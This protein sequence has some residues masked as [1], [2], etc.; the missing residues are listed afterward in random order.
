[1]ATPSPASD[2]VA[3]NGRTATAG[4]PSRSPGATHSPAPET[5]AAD[6]NERENVDDITATPPA[7][8]PSGATAGTADGG[9]SE[10]PSGATPEDPADASAPAAETGDPDATPVP[11]YSG[12]KIA[13]EVPEGGGTKNTSS[14]G[15]IIM[16]IIVALALISVASGIVEKIVRYYKNKN[17][18]GGSGNEKR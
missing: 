6:V 16:I 11:T 8:A 18:S 12:N 9:P 17:R 1:M 5:E 3:G 15:G 10:A 13:F 7:E 2:N 14:A 4:T